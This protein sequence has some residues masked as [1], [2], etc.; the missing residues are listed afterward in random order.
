[1]AIFMSKELNMYDFIQASDVFATKDGGFVII[2]NEDY[3]SGYI[4]SAVMGLMPTC[5]WF[6]KNK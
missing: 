2:L 6:G 4:Y 3:G 1:M 5:R